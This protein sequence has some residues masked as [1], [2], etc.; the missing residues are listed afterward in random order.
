MNKFVLLS[1]ILFSVFLNLSGV[2]Y[3]QN[4]VAWELSS[5]YGVTAGGVHSSTNA[6]GAGMGILSRGA[7]INATSITAA[8]SSNGWYSGPNATTLTTAAANNDYYQFTVPIEAG[9]TADIA[10]IQVY[11]QAS[12]TGPGSV[13]LRSSIDGFVADLG[14][15][16]VPTAS[17]L[18]TFIVSLSGLTGMVT[19]R[20]YGYGNSAGGANPGPG[21]T[22][23]IGSSPTT[24]ANDL[25]VIG[26][27]EYDGI[28]PF[29]TSRPA[30]LTDFS[31]VLGQ[32]SSVQSY[33]VSG[34][35]LPGDLVI[36]AQSENIEISISES[37][38]FSDRVAL[39]PIGGEVPGT[40][41][42]ARLTGVGT[43]VFS[44]QFIEHTSTGALSRTVA[45]SG[46][47]ND[48]STVI[49]IAAARAQPANIPV[50]VG[51]RI[52]AQ[53]G[54]LVYVQDATGGIPVFSSTFA[55]AVSVGDSVKVTGNR[56]DFNG[57]KQLGGM[58]IFT[59]YEVPSFV[60]APVTIQPDQ[61]S[62]FEGRL[63]K[64]ENEAF[65]A[66]YT[67]TSPQYLYDTAFV[68]IADNNYQLRGEA[69]SNQL[70][71]SFFT[72]I[73]GS[74]VPDNSFSVTG[75]VGVFNTVY[76]LFPRSRND[77]MPA[78]VPYVNTAGSSLP[79]DSTLDIV[80]WN[81]EWF[82]NGTPGNG[83]SDEAG[84]YSNV[85]Q[86]LRTTNADIY[87]VQE[88]SDISDFNRLL[89]SLSVNGYNGSCSKYTSNLPNGQTT[90]IN[91]AGQTIPCSSCVGHPMPIVTFYADS[92]FQRACIIYKTALVTL[93]SEQ[94]LLRLTPAPFPY[95]YPSDWGN[96]QASGR[97][98]YLWV[99]D[100][101]IGGITK[102]LHMVGIHAKANT[103]P[104]QESY[105]RRKYDIKVL[106][107][108]L[109]AQY[110][111][112]NIMLLGDYND[113]V[114]LTVA[115]IPSAE[116]TYKS[117]VDDVSRFRVVTTRLS[118]MNFRSYLTRRNVIDHITISNELFNNY[119]DGSGD[120]LF[121]F[122]YIS[123]Y[124]S[125]T[126]DHL[127]VIARFR[128][129]DC[130]VSHNFVERIINNPVNYKTST[131]I[132]SSALIKSSANVTYDAGRVVLL[133]PGFQTET[134]AGFQAFIE[135]C[136]EN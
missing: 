107:D 65:R 41:I 83:P 76:Q 73:A 64:V 82:G 121:P 126:S 105:E 35:S 134:G 91:A 11:F 60:P 44:N 23:R 12:G 114:D 62:A 42:Y 7:G 28:T 85:L 135:G 26:S 109:N 32:P 10:S 16:S 53:L 38:P 119:L 69:V 31:T 78:L 17:A 8:Y 128:L 122:K 127:P 103:E 123:S 96:F 3:T 56:E 25:V 79:A 20:L 68:F 115:N 120:L 4:L 81:I 58:V 77:F 136:S 118:D 87:V 88:I 6:D 129:R 101:A 116:S 18:R 111:T 75:V 2:A 80:S 70:R 133:K 132:T 95:D 19:F 15:V 47:V 30:A 108:T 51:G 92:T 99:V 5:L 93:I 52:T 14:T 113:D 117:I 21:G 94:P 37:G 36:T 67:E 45:V 84:Q 110:S 1:G 112:A 74:Y 55:K 43:G 54:G 66:D 49:A 90:T 89:D 22:L 13:T 61:F 29:I 57:Q 34:K 124:G 130:S 131:E 71:I 27:V 72:D 33:T 24:L 39:V 46:T 48:P 106:K 50:T 40:V 63:V 97:Y 102:R 125:S 86:V 59:K 100:V 9:M 104:L 98:P